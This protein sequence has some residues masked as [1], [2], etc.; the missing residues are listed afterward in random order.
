MNSQIKGHK[1]KGKVREIKIYRKENKLNDK[2]KEISRMKNKC[3]INRKAK[4]TNNKEK[5]EKDRKE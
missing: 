4:K 1:Q 5:N 3:I 2:E